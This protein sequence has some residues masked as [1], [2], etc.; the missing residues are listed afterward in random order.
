MQSGETVKSYISRAISLLGDLRELNREV[1][2]EDLSIT[3]LNGLTSEYRPVL[4]ALQ[5]SNLPL[6]VDRVRTTLQCYVQHAEQEPKALKAG[7][8]SGKKKKFRRKFENGKMKCWIC[9][10]EGH[11]KANCP[12]KGAIQ[13]RQ[14]NKRNGNALTAFMAMKE[15]LDTAM[16]DWVVDSGA[17]EHM[18]GNRDWFGDILSLNG[19]GNI[20]TA[21]GSLQAEGRGDVY[22]SKGDLK[23][24]LKD[25]LYVPGLKYNLFSV[26]K[27]VN[28][29]ARVSFEG[30]GCTI[31]KGQVILQATP[32]SDG[33]MV[34]LTTAKKWHAKLGHPSVYALKELGLPW[35][36]PKECEVCPKAKLSRTPHNSDPK[37]WLPLD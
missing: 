16:G 20:Y 29:G 25:V 33:T 13:S 14:V 32:Q 34:L 17:S 7:A 37:E 5:T 21:S 22:L 36:L 28:S 6:T 24:V 27:A 12:N 1:T 26:S 2:E 9:D 4:L 11:V 8:R 23:L 30:N 19:K 15:D 18:T 3:I 10:E 35:K 31:E